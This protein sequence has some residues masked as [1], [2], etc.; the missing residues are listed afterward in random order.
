MIKGPYLNL[1]W[2]SE[3]R[4]D[5]V[6]VVLGWGR[7]HWSDGVP[8]RLQMMRVHLCDEPPAYVPSATGVHISQHPL[9]HGPEKGDSGG[10]LLSDWNTLCGIVSRSYETAFA[11]SVLHTDILHHRPWIEKVVREINET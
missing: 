1:P 10:P 5:D 6:P 7:T 8:C 9:G 2:A 11:R 4:V 3:A